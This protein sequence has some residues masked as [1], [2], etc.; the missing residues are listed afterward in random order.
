VPSPSTAAPQHQEHM[1][2]GEAGGGITEGAPQERDEFL[3]AAQHLSLC[4]CR[5]EGAVPPTPQDELACDLFVEPVPPLV[6]VSARG[7]GAILQFL[8]FRGGCHLPTAVATIHGC[9]ASKLPL[10]WCLGLASLPVRLQ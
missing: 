8:R 3:V 5:E 1:L 2:A 4:H 9:Q 6:G 7:K 10:L